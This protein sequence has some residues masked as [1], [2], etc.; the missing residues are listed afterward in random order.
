MKTTHI[1]GTSN[2]CYIYR[3]INVLI[4]ILGKYKGGQH[5]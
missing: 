3:S 5:Y 1:D 2:L 4:I